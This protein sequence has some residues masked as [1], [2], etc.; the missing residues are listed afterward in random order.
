M[1]TLEPTYRFDRIKFNHVFAL[2]IFFFCVNVSWKR[3][4]KKHEIPLNIYIY[5][6]RYLLH[7]SNRYACL[8][9][10]VFVSG[11]TTNDNENRRRETKKKKSK[12]KLQEND[13]QD[14]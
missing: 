10:C 11:A 14:L 2:W 1:Q 9:Y 12:K 3:M 7:P 5:I 4:K 6:Y 13:N 8:G